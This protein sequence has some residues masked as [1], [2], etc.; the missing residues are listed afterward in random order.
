MQP[1]SLGIPQTRDIPGHFA[2]DP[3]GF[4]KKLAEI[5]YK[6][7]TP[8]AQKVGPENFPKNFD[9]KIF[10]F[11]YRVFSNIFSEKSSREL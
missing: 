6:T 2:F 8:R 11:S 4:H 3:K 7:S 1:V 10:S 5:R 9:L